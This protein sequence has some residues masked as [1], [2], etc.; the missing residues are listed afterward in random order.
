M[1]QRLLA[2]LL[3]ISLLAALAACGGNDDITESTDPSTSGADTTAAKDLPLVESTCKLPYSKADTLDPYQCKTMINQ[4]LSSLLY[5]SLFRLDAQYRPNRL[6]ASNYTV[7]GKTLSVTLVSDRS[8][9]DG[10]KIT[11]ADVVAAFNLAKNSPH[12]KEQLSNVQTATAKGNVITFTLKAEDPYAVSCLDFAIGKVRKGAIPLGS[13]RY[14]L[15]EEAH[16]VRLQANTKYPDFSP[17]LATLALVDATD[18]S[19]LPN[20]IAIGNVSFAY[21]DLSDGKYQRVS[22]S[23]SEVG[24]NNL[25]YLVCNS[26]RTMTSKP[27]FRQAVNLL[28]DREKVAQSA[29][30]NHARA[31]AAPWNPDWFAV[32]GKTM[33]ILPDATT[34]AKLLKAA[35]V[36]AKDSYTLL[37]NQDNTF[38]L[39][40]A[41]LIATQ[42][43]AGGINVKVDAQANNAYRSSVQNGSYDL[44]LG[45]VRLTYNMDLSPLLQSGGNV[46]YGI[47]AGNAAAQAYTK[48]C[49]GE[50]TIDVFWESFQ[51]DLPF[52]PL[53]YRNAIALYSRSMKISDSMHETDL[54]SGI[55]DWAFLQ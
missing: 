37:V 29:F 8:F 36:T 34:A 55:A 50:I 51:E 38:K 25:I 45:E 23:M 54:F 32:K 47:S 21:D 52:L 39:A 16:S 15:K 41:N 42:L 26:R 19:A 24:M 10:S 43:K 40:A 5:D 46:S 33:A 28:L 30:Q 53:C 13:G 49:A 31:T 2:I 3:L 6:L 22:A 27:E 1:K 44:Y 14:V 48:F 12:Y 9:S 4:Q 17:R 11:A 18:S 20:S 7:A 35:G